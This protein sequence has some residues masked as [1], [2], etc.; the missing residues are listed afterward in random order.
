MPNHDGSTKEPSAEEE[1][2]LE[3]FKERLALEKRIGERM[4]R[5]GHKILIA[6]GKGGVG[7]TTAAVNLALGLAEAGDSVALLDADIHGP[8][9]PLMLGLAGARPTGTEEGINPVAYDDNLVVMSMAFL[10]A[11]DS[12]A[13]IWRGPLK[14]AMVDNFL[15]D[16]NWGDRDWFVVD[17]PPGTGDEI[18]S[19]AQRI[20]DVDGL[21]MITTPQEAALASARKSLTFAVKT[22]IPILGVVENMGPVACPA[23][24]HEM[25][26][27]GE[28]GGPRVAAEF[29]VPFL[30]SVP[31]DPEAV[32]ESDRG[33]PLLLTDRDSP[34]AAAWREIVARLR[35]VVAQ[36]E[37]SRSE[38]A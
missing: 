3:R 5:V 7:K 10:L 21:I 37:A 9:V 23:C 28:G 6:S 15:A 19:L 33:Q 32:P 16:I 31:F 4:G 1:A 17:T 36:R 8:G 24:G 11:G 30:G 27:F 12:D 13:V 35:E 38:E 25:K 34:A 22:N 26:L 18:L 20:K 2:K 29:G 14:M